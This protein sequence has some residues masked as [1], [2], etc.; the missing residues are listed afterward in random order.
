MAFSNI[1]YFCWFTCP[2]LFSLVILPIPSCPFILYRLLSKQSLAYLEFMTLYSN[3]RRI[4]VVTYCIA[5]RIAAW[6]H[7]WPTKPNTLWGVKGVVN[8]FSQTSILRSISDK[9]GHM[10]IM[11]MPQ[12]FLGSFI[13]LMLK[14]K[15]YFYFPMAEQFAWG[16]GAKL[17]TSACSSD[18]YHKT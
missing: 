9:L 1:I 2:S 6:P 16:D 8:N 5:W 17:K 18:L 13:H 11:L 15:G 10:A 14:D 3:W 7:K 12:A 4:T